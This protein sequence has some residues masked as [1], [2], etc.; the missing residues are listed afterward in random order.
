MSDVASVPVIDNITSNNI[1]EADYISKH[2]TDSTNNEINQN[3][4]IETET[5]KEYEIGPTGT[6]SNITNDQDQRAPEKIPSDAREYKLDDEDEQDNGSV[7]VI[8]LQCET[9]SCDANINN[10]KRAFSDPYF[11]VQV[12]AVDSPP[13]HNPNIKTLNNFQYTEN[14]FMRKALAYAAEGP[15]LTNSQGLIEPQQWWNNIPVIIVKDSSVSNVTLPSGANDPLYIQ[16]GSTN[17]KSRI[18]E[19]KSSNP[20]NLALDNNKLYN[21]G[22]K[23]R[24]A[25]A[26]DRAKEADLF[27][28]CK[29]HDACN[30]Y[31]DVENTDNTNHGSTLKWS[32]QPTATQ[33]IMYTSRSRDYIHNALLTATIPLSDILNIN[34]SKGN[35]LATVFVPNIIDFDIDLA[36]SNEDYNKLNECAPVQESTTNTTNTASILWLIIIIIIIILVA[37][38]LIQLG[39]RYVST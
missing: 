18:S 2:G 38:A 14:Y 12:C 9:K 7:L 37:W 32:V 35:L 1:I 24:I 36:T 31:V 23:R 4:T 21:E 11:T 26:L 16:Y 3:K 34:I 30:K 8:I 10:L 20:D 19:P 13:P 27:F 5:N 28:L 15:Y 39:P 29:W 6:H 22:M 33:A 17:R 25:L